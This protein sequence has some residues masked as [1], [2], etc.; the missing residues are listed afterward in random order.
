MRKFNK[1]Y[2]IVFGLIALFW[3]ISLI[4]ESGDLWTS[5]YDRT[6]GNS[7]WRI[8]SG[9]A[10]IPGKDNTYTL[11][12]ASYQPSTVYG[13]NGILSGT[14]AVTGVPT[15]TTGVDIGEV[16]TFPTSGYGRGAIIFYT[17]TEDTTMKFYGSTA[18][19]TTASCWVALH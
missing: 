3:A 16:S 15:F 19:V 13:V 18:T 1:L 8:N 5:S 6:N 10:L 14:L 11:G 17:G 2:L 7:H 4:A 12:S 9:G